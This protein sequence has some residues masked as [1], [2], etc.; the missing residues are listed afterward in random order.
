[1]FVSVITSQAGKRLDVLLA[2][3][4]FAQPQ[5]TKAE[6]ARRLGVSHPRMRQIVGRLWHHWDKAAPP[7]GVWQLQQ[8]ADRVRFGDAARRRSG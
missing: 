6:G 5:I 2:V 1:V 4:G 7:A 3:V 8:W